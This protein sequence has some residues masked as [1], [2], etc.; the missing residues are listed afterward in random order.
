MKLLK[1]FA[2]FARV[3]PFFLEKAHHGDTEAS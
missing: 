2:T 1:N 3:L